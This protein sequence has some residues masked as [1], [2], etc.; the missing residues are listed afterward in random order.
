MGLFLR[1]RMRTRFAVRRC[2]LDEKADSP[3]KGVNLAEEL[4]EYVLGQIL[5]L[6]GL[7]HHAQAK[8]VDAPTVESVDELECRGVSLLSQPDGFA[9][10][11]AVRFVRL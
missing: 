5:G 6:D 3:R 4:Q 2:N 9:Q 8:G 7:S 1:K 11:G 10:G